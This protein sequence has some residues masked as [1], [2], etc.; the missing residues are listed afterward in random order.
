ME[1]RTLPERNGIP[2][3]QYYVDDAGK[4][5]GLV[6]AAGKTTDTSAGTGTSATGKSSLADLRYKK[7]PKIEAA[8]SGTG[9]SATGT[10]VEKDL[11]PGKGM[12][13]ID[14]TKG[15]TQKARELLL[16][17]DLQ[18]AVNLLEEG[19]GTTST[20]DAQTLQAFEDFA[21]KSGTAVVD[22]GDTETIDPNLNVGEISK[23]QN[24]DIP[25]GA[26]DLGATHYNS[27][28]GQYGTIGESVTKNVGTGV[29]ED[30]VIEGLFVNKEGEPEEVVTYKTDISERP[31]L[32]TLDVNDIMDRGGRGKWGADLHSYIDLPDGQGGTK[33]IKTKDEVAITQEMLDDGLSDH[34]YYGGN[35]AV[36]DKVRGTGG[37]VANVFLQAK[38]H[39]KELNVGQQEKIDAWDKENKVVELKPTIIKVPATQ[40]V[41][42]TKAV[43]TIGKFEP[44]D[45]K[46]Q[47]VTVPK[48]EEVKEEEDTI[49]KPVTDAIDVDELANINVLQNQS[50]D[51][52]PGGLKT[53]GTF[54]TPEQIDK[55]NAAITQ[56][57]PLIAQPVAVNVPQ[58]TYTAQ[59]TPTQ[60][61]QPQPTTQTGTATNTYGMADVSGTQQTPLQTAGLSAVP[62]TVMVRPQYTGTTMQNL[63]SISQQGFGG[64]A[65]Y[66][67]KFGQRVT[68]SL[69]GTGKPLT[70][71]PPGFRRGVPDGQGGYTYPGDSVQGQYQGGLTGYA[72]GGTVSNLQGQLRL[73]NK[74]LGYT[75]EATQDSLNA[76][77]N[78]N[79]G[80]AAK[81]GKYQQAMSNMAQPIQQMYRGGPVRGFDAGGTPVNGVS[82][83]VGHTSHLDGSKHIAEG[84]DLDFYYD[85]ARPMAKSAIEQTM[86]PMQ[87]TVNYI[88]PTPADFIGSTAGQT[89]P[90][91]PMAD[92]ATVGSVTQSQMAQTKAPGTYDATGVASDVAKVLEGG[93]TLDHEK[94]I[95]ATPEIGLGQKDSYD[96]KSGKFIRVT[97]DTVVPMF[98]EYTPE[99]YAKLTG[100]NLSDF[101]TTYGGL[102]PA[103]G[104]KPADIVDEQKTTSAVSGLEAA[105]G[106]MQKFD[107]VTGMP[108]IPDPDK[109]LF[110]PAEN[111]FKR[112]LTRDPVTGDFTELVSGSANAAKAAAFTEQIQADTATPTA[113]ATVKGQL[114]LLMKDFEGG[115]TPA[116]AAGSMRAATA[117]MAARGLGASSMAGQAIIQATME[118]A[119]PIAMADAQT[120]ARFEAQ[121][122]SNKQQVQMLRAQQRAQFMGQEFDQDFQARVQNAAKISDIAN[123]NFSADQTIQLENSRNA[124]TLSMANL[125]NTQSLVMAEAAA[126]AG[127]DTQ[128]LNNRQQ[129]AVQNAQNFLAMDMAN[130]TN[131]Q[132][133]AMFKTQQNVQALFTDQAAENAS[134][135]FN[136]SSTNQTNQFFANLSTQTAQF[137]AAQTN[138]MDQFNVNA[139]N[140][141][142]EFNSSLQQQRDMFNAQNGLVIAQANAQWRQNITTLNNAT[143]NESNM[144][145]AKTMNALTSKN[146]DAI[147]QRERDLMDQAYKVNESKLDRAVS[148]LIADKTLEGIK[149]KIDEDGKTANAE[150]LWKLLF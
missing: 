36:S 58:P 125:S 33:R 57:D 35:A 85:R 112:E 92:A 60:T 49:T 110:K 100:K 124:Q 73:A 81:M 30:K 61:F 2:G 64:Q 126:L 132:Q 149:L 127:L 78:S 11:Q 133:T 65:V 32:Y 87:G 31:Q 74:F 117:A 123:Q 131:K 119:L 138:A 136:A 118:A 105:T 94:L 130:L 48:E 113:K 45:F 147:W 18:G 55:S 28:T 54:V 5:A 69:D 137:N 146:I 143:Q 102:Q 63:S 38:E 115:D 16:A 21:T 98:K 56:M 42:K 134:K 84:T 150:L 142:R 10:S 26:L 1:I 67:N 14:D 144:D 25:Q 43:T 107:P 23:L 148:V 86:Q 66:V 34:S 70:Y 76:F 99:E 50:P 24:V 135:Q 51:V 104:D 83:A 40:K 139:V 75:G 96:E 122:L 12:P 145:F 3:R 17:G 53:E 8:L 141:L 82:D 93:V 29:F 77:L 109:E 59:P 89:A 106:Q 128:N 121:N 129:A 15:Y 140:G 37:E 20:T 46:Q 103:K 90:I 95:K 52:I 116:W 4:F 68:I 114:D 62:Q 120:L 22:S 80:A 19:S 9:T 91:A 79:P 72:P 71:V 111:K 88:T 97:Q 41:E 39:I 7:N 101:Q 13:V 108:L 27:A 44:F 6:P 47:K